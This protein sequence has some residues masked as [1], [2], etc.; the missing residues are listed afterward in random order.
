[1]NV[2]EF[3]DATCVK[4]IGRQGT[5]DW[6]PIFYVESYKRR[7]FKKSIHKLLFENALKHMNNNKELIRHICSSSRIDLKLA[8][9]TRFI[10]RI[11]ANICSHFY[12]T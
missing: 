3:L 12:N 8:S 2:R 1:M 10:L 5:W 7:V 6:P 4:W 11:A 9:N